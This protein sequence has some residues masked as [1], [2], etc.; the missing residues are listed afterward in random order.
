MTGHVDFDLC[1][2]CGGSVKALVYY[3][4]PSGRDVSYCGS[5]NKR[6]QDAI[7]EQ[8]GRLLYD[9]QYTLEEN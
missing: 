2:K 7:V 3:V 5:C 1:D 8:G 6:F 9:F 4:L